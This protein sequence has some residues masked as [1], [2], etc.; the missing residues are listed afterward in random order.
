MDGFVTVFE[1]AGGNQRIGREWGQVY[2]V[3][4]IIIIVV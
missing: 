2:F 3:G 4:I 1:I